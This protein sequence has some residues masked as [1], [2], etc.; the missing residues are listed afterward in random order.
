MS[1]ESA[2]RQSEV[3]A[4]LADERKAVT[5]RTKKFSAAELERMKEAVKDG[6]PQTM[7]CSRFGIHASTLRILLKGK[8]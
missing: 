6:V 5:S 7:V 8:P 4:R 3:R 1:V 2:Y